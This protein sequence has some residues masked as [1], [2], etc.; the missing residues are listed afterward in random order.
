MAQG[1]SKLSRDIMTALRARGVFCFK[2]HGGA[3]MMAGL[4]DIIACVPEHLDIPGGYVATF[5]RFVGIETKMPGGGN[6]TPI[7]LHR[8]TEIAG[9]GGTVIVARSVADVLAWLDPPD[10]TPDAI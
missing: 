10:T 7:Q 1:E 9:A 8:H 2:V 3:T 4:P 5:G 6:P